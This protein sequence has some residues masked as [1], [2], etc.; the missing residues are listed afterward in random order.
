[1]NTIVSSF[2]YLNANR[3]RPLEKYLDFGSKILNINIPKI[4]FIEPASFEYLKDKTFPQTHFILIERNNLFLWNLKDT[5]KKDQLNANKEKDT[6]EYLTILANKT[7]WVSSAIDLNPFKTDQFTWIDF[8]IYH[9]MGPSYNIPGDETLFI[10]NI[11][12]IEKKQYQKV[13]IA[14]IWDLNKDYG[15]NWQKD[16]MWYFAGSVFGGSS[17]SL[18]EFASK[19]K[20]LYLDTLKDIGYIPFEF[21]IWY[22]IYK[23]NPEL[24]SPY[25]C[26]HNTSILENY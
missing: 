6:N 20:Q 15:K 26:N 7:E 10:K 22:Q 9:M 24:F 5:F 19:T 17:S 25:E 8:G 12:Q 3:Y 4:I 14:S 11:Q 1:M 13:R 21:N 23:Q 16:I 2:I 18:K